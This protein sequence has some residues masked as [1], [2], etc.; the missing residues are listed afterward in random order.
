LNKSSKTGFN[1]LSLFFISV[2]LIGLF[3]LA[4]L[5][6]CIPIL[7]VNFSWQKPVVGSV[8]GIICLS[9]ITAGVYPSRCSR[10]LH[11]RKKMQSK[12]HY[13]A[14]QGSVRE[15]IVTFEGHHPNCGNFPAHVLQL[16]DKKYCAGCTGLVVGA[17]LSL[18]GTPVYLFTGFFLRGMAPLL[19]WLGFAGVASGLLQYDL[20]NT[21]R[22]FVHFSLN[23][24]FVFGAFL[25]L[26]GIEEITGNIVLDVYLVTLTLYWVLTRILLSQ[27]E[28]RKICAACGLETCPFSE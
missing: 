8:F 9:G 26:I 1:V 28:H 2:S 4:A 27:Q 13:D 19:F 5:T 23:V 24:I 10:M 22:S 17:M 20:F 25:L 7:K 11:F 14:E 12:R 3:L 6:F 15:R 21:C 16:G 18:S